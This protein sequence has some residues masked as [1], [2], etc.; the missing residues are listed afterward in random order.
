MAGLPASPNGN[1]HCLRAC[2][3][4]TTRDESGQ[5]T[6]HGVKQ[7]PSGMLA[8]DGPP[9]TLGP[10]GRDWVAF[11]QGSATR[12]ATY[13]VNGTPVGARDIFQVPTSVHMLPAY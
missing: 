11:L 3:Q 10:S 7:L 12:D 9:T 5:I 13:F 1:N 6:A 2:L 4:V 8:P